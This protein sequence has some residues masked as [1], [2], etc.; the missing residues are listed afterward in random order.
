M[1]NK[2]IMSGLKPIKARKPKT[3]ERFGVPHKNATLKRLNGGKLNIMGLKAVQY[4]Y[5]MV[6]C[7]WP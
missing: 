2:P 4:A 3:L 1:E 7:V 5:I 6:W